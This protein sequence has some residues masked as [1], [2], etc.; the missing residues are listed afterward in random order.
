M[1]ELM[2][3]M[4]QLPF[5]MLTCC[6]N[7]LAM[8]MTSVQQRPMSYAGDFP[9]V[10]EPP[11]QNELRIA[12]GTELSEDLSNRWNPGAPG[13]GALKETK[14]EKTMSDRYC[15]C[16]RDETV[17]LVEYSIV[18]IK[19]C[20]ERVI[21]RGEV[22]YVDDMS[23]DGFAAWVIARYFQGDDLPEGD[24][25]RRKREIPVAEKRYLRVYHNVLASWTSPE[26]DCEN[27]QLD[28]L[29][30]IENAIRNLGGGLR[31]EEAPA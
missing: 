21:Q 6:M 9:G 13:D 8:T 28:V 12:P 2:G 31:R 29:R 20:E 22:I 4:M 7:V 19:P 24:E 3:Q 30:G 1:F 27:R 11:R 15:R 25:R 17:K 18:S 23:D 5:T 10:R 14:E 26:D 16:D